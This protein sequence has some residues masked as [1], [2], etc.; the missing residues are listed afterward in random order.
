METVH[1]S[2]VDEK[3]M[4]TE[5][6][7]A[8]R[9]SFR[10][11]EE[12]GRAWILEDGYRRRFNRDGYRVGDGS[13]EHFKRLVFKDTVILPFDV[14]KGGHSGG[15]RPLIDLYQLWRFHPEMTNLGVRFHL[16]AAFPFANLILLLVGLPFALRTRSNSFFL[17]A[18]QSALIVGAFFITTYLCMRLG[19][20]GILPPLFAGWLPA[21]LFGSAGTVLFRIIPT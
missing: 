2:R 3:L 21:A 14:E 5:H 7:Y 8:A 11:L 17:G 10:T 9:G 6:I 20:S 16:R 18:A 12:G 4:E 19:Y 13:Q 15:L 1:I